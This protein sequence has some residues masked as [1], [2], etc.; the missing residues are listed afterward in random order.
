MSNL[1]GIVRDMGGL[2]AILPFAILFA[3]LIL[4]IVWLVAFG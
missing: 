2:R 4:L 1:K 3:V